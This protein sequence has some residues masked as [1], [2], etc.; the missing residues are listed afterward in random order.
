MAANSPAGLLRMPPG[1][2]ELYASACRVLGADLRVRALWVSGSLARGDSDAASDLDLIVTVADESHAI[3]AEGWRGWL[4]QIT[5][6][7]LARPIPFFAGSFYSLTPGCERFDVIVEK[8]SQLPTS[9][10]AV[11]FAVFDRDGLAAKL[12]AP[13][14]GG[15]PDRAKLETAI[16]EPLRYLAMLPAMLGRG[17]LL[18]TQEAWGHLRRRISELFLEANAPLPVTGVKHWRDKLTPEQYTV[19]ESLEWPAAERK[20]LIDAHVAV[21]R[22]L[23]LHGKSIAARVGVAWPQLLEDAVRSHLR[24]ELGVE[25]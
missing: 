17:D 7:V 19:L 10:F 4:A 14:P 18:L 23:F 11:R 5:P 3:F 6:T 9:M 12:P 8:V 24:K 1:Y 21:A 15:G 13:R 2:T 25:L 16:E 20:A 22:A